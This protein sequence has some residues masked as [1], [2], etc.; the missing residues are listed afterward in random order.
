MQMT[1][2][3]HRYLVH[4][5]CGHYFYYT[6]GARL[7]AR[8]I[9]ELQRDCSHKVCPSCQKEREAENAK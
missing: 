1:I 2:Q 6:T 3:D 9:A 4:Y 5:A 7:S 8:A